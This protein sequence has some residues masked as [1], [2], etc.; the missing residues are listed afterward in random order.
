[1]T[2]LRIGPSVIFMFLVSDILSVDPVIKKLQPL[3]VLKGIPQAPL[4]REEPE[5]L[6]ADVLHPFHLV[7]IEL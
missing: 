4:T 5:I 1:M 6:P 2:A 7:K 3:V